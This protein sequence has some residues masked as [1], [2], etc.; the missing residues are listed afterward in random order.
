MKHKFTLMDLFIVLALVLIVAPI[1]RP[2]MLSA[3]FAPLRGLV[4]Q[5]VSR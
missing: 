2:R 1:V 4:Q 3:T 5:H